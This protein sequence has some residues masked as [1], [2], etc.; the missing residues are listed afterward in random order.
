LFYRYDIYPEYLELMNKV[1]NNNP[2]DPNY[3]SY[4]Q[5]FSVVEDRILNI[6][7]GSY[8]QMIRIYIVM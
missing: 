2:S 6:A 7:N 5:Q 8:D 3:S 4:Q 1:D